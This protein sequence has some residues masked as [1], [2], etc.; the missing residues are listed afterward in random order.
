VRIQLVD[1]ERVSPLVHVR[2]VGLGGLVLAIPNQVAI[3]L[4]SLRTIALL[5]V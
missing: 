1:I 4:D 2:V 3:D 5:S